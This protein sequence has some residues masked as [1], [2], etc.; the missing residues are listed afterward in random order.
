M[1][2]RLLIDAW[3][4]QSPR[5]YTGETYVPGGPITLRLEYFENTGGALVWLTWA[6]SSVSPQA[7]L[8]QRTGVTQLE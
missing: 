4:V 5:T 8:D 7:L 2:D 1:N 3:Y 6:R